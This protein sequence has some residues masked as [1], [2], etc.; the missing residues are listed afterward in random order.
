MYFLG[1][2]PP[3]K[4]DLR[5]TVLIGASPHG[6]AIRIGQIPGLL[7][8]VQNRFDGLAVV[9][10]PNKNAA[11]SAIPVIGKVRGDLY[12]VI[13]QRG[14]VSQQFSFFFLLVVV[15]EGWSGVEVVAA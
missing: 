15:G 10:A 9:K 13:L 12:P 7:D 5:F 3:A 6:E 2:V 4:K 8:V 1:Y 11:F 14:A